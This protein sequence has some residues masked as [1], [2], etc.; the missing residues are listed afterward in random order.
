MLGPQISYAK[1]DAVKAVDGK[2]P[3]VVIAMAGGVAYLTV[4]SKRRREA[5]TL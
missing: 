5:H 3:V 1:N 2:I 4:Q